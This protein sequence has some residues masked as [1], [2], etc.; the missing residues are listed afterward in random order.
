MS[1]TLDTLT[2]RILKLSSD[3]QSGIEP[4][5]FYSWW[6]PADCRADPAVAPVTHE[7]PPDHEFQ[8]FHFVMFCLSALMIK[9]FL[10]HPCPNAFT[11][12]IIMTSSPGTVHTLHNAIFLNDC[13]ICSTGILAAAVGMHNGSA[14]FRETQ[15]RMVQCF[16]AQ[17]GTHMVCHGK[18]IW[19]Q[20]IAIK[21][22]RNIQLS[23]FCLDFSNVCNAFFQRCICCKITFQK[24]IRFTGF[25]VGFGD[26]VG[27]SLGSVKHL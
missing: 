12:R 19:H 5:P 20:I 18:T 15:I 23:V 2:A 17:F 13:P 11:S 22:R 14:D 24:I 16:T 10:F 9:Q 4:T 26:S 21:N 1:I 27:L 3:S 25:T 6:N 7:I 8:L